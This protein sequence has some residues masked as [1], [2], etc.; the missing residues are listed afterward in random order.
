MR[1]SVRCGPPDQPAEHICCL[2]I[3]KQ[4]ELREFRKQ[5]DRSASFGRRASRPLEAKWRLNLPRSPLCEGC[6]GRTL[7]A[8]EGSSGSKAWKCGPCVRAI[9]EV[10]FLIASSF[11]CVLSSPTLTR[12]RFHMAGIY[13]ST[14]KTGTK[15]P[16]AA[17]GNTRDWNHKQQ[18]G[19][20]KLSRLREVSSRQFSVLLICPLWQLCAVSR[21]N[22]AE[23]ARDNQAAHYFERRGVTV[24]DY[25]RLR[26]TG[27]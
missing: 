18:G 26:R 3:L 27:E 23:P 17:R 5:E 1:R 10:P 21:R 24:T 4:A 14:R 15:S 11:C 16:T 12:P 20:C 6:G 2:Q 19:P 13:T 25:K 22:P 7:A 9:E 8:A